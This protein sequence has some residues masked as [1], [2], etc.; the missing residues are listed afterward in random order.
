[1]KKKKKKKGIS[2][3]LTCCWNRNGA[4]RKEKTSR[5]EWKEKGYIEGL[6]VCVVEN[7]EREGDERIELIE[8]IVQM[9][10][11]CVFFFFLLL[12][13]SIFANHLQTSSPEGES[14]TASKC[15]WLLPERAPSC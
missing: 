4:T 3:S 6:C 5:E 14:S 2:R 9:Q 11:I 8:Q 10:P 7:V 15:R 12:S 13:F 1:M